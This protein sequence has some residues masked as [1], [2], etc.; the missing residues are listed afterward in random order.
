MTEREFQDQVLLALGGIRAD[1]YNIK[2]DLNENRSDH[3]AI[4]DR[5]GETEK[6]LEGIKVKTGIMG[7]IVGGVAGIVAG[8]LAGIFGGRFGS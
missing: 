3:K 7:S 8:T 2:N 1:L 4:Y 6:C 5:L